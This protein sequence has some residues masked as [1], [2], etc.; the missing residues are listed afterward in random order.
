MLKVT[1]PYGTHGSTVIIFM[2]ISHLTTT[3]AAQTPTQG[4]SPLTFLSFH[5]RM[6]RSTKVTKLVY[7]TDSDDEDDVEAVAHATSCGHETDHG[8][9]EGLG[10]EGKDEDEREIEIVGN[11]AGDKDHR[12][13]GKR[14][15]LSKMTQSAGEVALS[16][17]MDRKEHSGPVFHF[18]VS[19]Y[20]NRVWLYSLDDKSFHVNLHPTEFQHDPHAFLPEHLASPSAV[21]SVLSFVRQLMRLR[22]IQRRQLSNRI[23]ASVKHGLSDSKEATPASLVKRA[24]SSTTRF[25]AVQDFDK[26][27]KKAKDKVRRDEVTTT[28]KRDVKEG[29][30]DTASFVTPNHS[31][32]PQSW[33]PH[34][35]VKSRTTTAKSKQCKGSTVTPFKRAAQ[36][37]AKF[38][39]QT[40]STGASLSPTSVKSARTTSSSAATKSSPYFSHSDKDETPSASRRPT[41]GKRS[42]TGNSPSQTRQL[43]PTSSGKATVHTTCTYVHMHTYTLGVMR[44][45]L[46][47]ICLPQLHERIYSENTHTK[48]YISLLSH[49]FLLLF[50]NGFG[51]A[52]RYCGKEVS[53]CMATSSVSKRSKQQRYNQ[54]CSHDCWEAY[55]VQVRDVKSFAHLHMVWKSCCI[56]WNPQLLMSLL[57]GR[58]FVLL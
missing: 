57:C 7:L 2:L 28:P 55:N 11:K 42:V 34:E 6:P 12:C 20:T 3:H 17:P 58:A 39:D 32:G 38:R 9:G 13:T 29:C 10:E 35:L 50:H 14:N 40:P 18:A 43:T 44:L 19:Q 47:R 5:S 15:A 24:S 37:K 52:V 23:I 53:V 25:T 30:T 22:P 46:T 56:Q 36:S 1:R 48:R 51:L 33:S 27:A 26:S 16:K 41:G 49:V 54:F 45:Y 8:E 4:A 21:S 31:S